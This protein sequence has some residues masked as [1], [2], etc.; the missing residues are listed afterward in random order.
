[1]P[2]APLMNPPTPEQLL[3]H[4]QVPEKRGVFVLGCFERRVTLYSQQVRALNLIHSLFELELLKE[5]ASLLVIGGGGAGLTAA[6]G[7]AVRGCKVTLLEERQELLPLFSGNQTRWLHPHI[8]EWPAP[9]STR[10]HAA[11][12]VLD[13]HAGMAGDVAEQLLQA[14]ESLKGSH[15]HRVHRGVG[16][17]QLQLKPR[18]PHRVS[19]NASSHHT[20]SFDVVILAVGFGLER[21]HAEQGFRSYWE[22]D[23]LHQPVGLPPKPEVRA[24][25]SGNGDGGLVDLFRLTLKS[26]RHDRIVTDFLSQT[27][28]RQLTEELLAIDDDVR[29]GRLQEDELYERYTKLKVPEELDA[30]LKQ[31]LRP[32]IKVT[33]NGKS[34]DPLSI[35]SS[36]LNRFLASQLL[37]KH[38]VIYRRGALAYTNGAPLEVTIGSDPPEVFDLIVARHG[39]EKPALQ[40]AFPSIWQAMEAHLPEVNLL[41]QTRIP[42]WPDGA[43]GPRSMPSRL[44]APVLASPLPERG[45]IIGRTDETERLV[46]SLLAS[47]PGATMVLGAPGIGKSTLLRAVLHDARIETHYGSNRYYVR[48]DGATTAEAMVASVARV[49]DIPLGE[50]LATRVEKRLSTGRVLLMLDNAETPWLAERPA[51]ETWLQKLVSAPELALVAALRG[52]E[53]PALQPHESHTERIPPLT[54]AEAIQ[55]FCSIATEVSPDDPLL[56]GLVGTP[57]RT[58]LSVVLLANMAAGVGL[59]ALREHW[60]HERTERPSPEQAR[61]TQDPASIEFSLTGPGMTGEAQKLLSLL[62]LFPSGVSFEDRKRLFP[63]STTALAGLQ[64][65]ALIQGS[66]ERWRILDPIRKYVRHRYP[67]TP[68]ERAPVVT[69][70]FAR[71][72]Q[73]GAKVGD[74]DGHAAMRQLG[75]EIDN[76]EALLLE[77]LGGGDIRQA[78]DTAIGLNN[79]IRYS[80]QGTIHPTERAVTMAKQQGDVRLQALSVQALGRLLLRRLRYREAHGYFQSALVLFEQVSDAQGQAQCLQDLGSVALIM[81]E[82]QQAWDYFQQ[83]LS[84]RQQAR[85]AR[86]EAYGLHNLGRAARYLNRPEEAR[87]LLE[88]S[89]HMFIHQKHLLGQAYCLRHLGE[90]NRDA[91]QIEQARTLFQQVGETR[92]VGHSHQSLGGLA[93]SAGRLDEARLHYEKSMDCFRQVHAY[94]EEARSLMGLAELALRCAQIPEAREQFTRALTLFQQA[95]EEESVRKCQAQL[96]K[97]EG[98]TD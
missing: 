96:E 70:Y 47:R 33:L 16:H 83:A 48:L 40:K 61:E 90:L 22:T 77:E 51:V 38:G 8:Y 75:A 19:W 49:L 79:F 39:P 80:G 69:A 60:K 2:P 21:Q 78:L 30:G 5:D 4:M 55:L 84:L 34:A 89:L 63:N 81:S 43:F 97:L 17:I 37:M 45:L 54:Q 27:M 56:P 25:V 7:A 72:R 29:C 15:E 11:L 73:L 68:E 42:M 44:G 57:G 93:L 58:T 6:A 67:P 24:L 12:P 95:G 88:E 86:G 87:R 9:G 31:R 85:D 82:P 71:A 53:S 26:F 76:L 1:M 62:A 92:N 20:G 14:W 13:W 3:Q 52:D 50:G 35:G 36:I 91:L 65:A 32:G 74:A 59:D 94:G 98:A 64:K 66:G 10:E 46:H 23:S 28:T 41:D 18:P